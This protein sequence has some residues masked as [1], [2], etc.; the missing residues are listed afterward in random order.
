MGRVS[1]FIRKSAKGMFH[2]RL[3]VFAQAL[4]GEDWFPFGCA[5]DKGTLRTTHVQYQNPKLIFYLIF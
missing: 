5:D 1:R 2:I 4:R 3:F